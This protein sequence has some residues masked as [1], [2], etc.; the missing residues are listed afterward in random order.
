MITLENID[1]V[2]LDQLK[3]H[4]PFIILLFILELRGHRMRMKLAFNL[5]LLSWSFYL[6]KELRLLL[7]GERIVLDSH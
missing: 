5:L 7:L 4:W 3:L 1:A 2:L 6:F